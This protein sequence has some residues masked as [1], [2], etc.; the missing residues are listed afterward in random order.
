MAENL[1]NRR[2][3]P[4]LAWRLFWLELWRL[5]APF[6]KLFRSIMAV[7][8]LASLLELIRPYILKIVI[9][10]LTAF[11]IAN[12]WFLTQLVILYWANEQIRSVIRYFNDRKILR[13]LVE[14]EYQLGVQAQEKL[15]SLSLGY[16][17]RENTGS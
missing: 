7:T 13:L 17:E 15:V 5:L 12:I 1:E 9:D 6:K 4:P 8:F 3:D 16:H 11:D 10:G 14:V 2:E